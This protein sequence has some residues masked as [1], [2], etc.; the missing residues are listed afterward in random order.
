M[1]LILASGS[2]RRKEIMEQVGL[3]FEIVPAKGEEFSKESSPIKRVEALSKEKTVEVV[4]LMK[5][6]MSEEEEITVIGADTLV[7]YGKTILGKPKDEED[8]KKMLR[9]LQGKKHHVY[10][11]VTIYV[12]KKKNEKYM[13]FHEKT[14][15]YMYPMNEE[16]IAEYVNTKEPMDKAGAYAIQGRCAKFIR[17]INGD[18]NNVV[19]LPIAKILHILSMFEKGI[20]K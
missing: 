15:V 10:T 13:V 3:Q 20:D 7:A 11:G 14:S 19:G 9:L 18:Y 12:R 1:R 4:E 2:P 16:Q 17:K 5:C 6:D 8:A